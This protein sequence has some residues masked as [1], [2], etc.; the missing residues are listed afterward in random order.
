MGFLYYNI[1]KVSYQLKQLF[2]NLVLWLW[3]CIYVILLN[4]LLYVKIYDYVLERSE[5]STC[6]QLFCCSF[7]LHQCTWTMSESLWC[8]MFR[9]TNF[10]RIWI[11]RGMLWT[12][13]MNPFTIWTWAYN[14]KS[15][16]VVWTTQGLSC[17][18][19]KA[20]KWV[21]KD[22]N[23]SAYLRSIQGPRSLLWSWHP[24][25]ENVETCR[26]SSSCCKIWMSHSFCHEGDQI[27]A[28]LI[29]LATPK[30]S[31]VS[32]RRNEELRFCHLD[33]TESVSYCWFV[34]SR[35]RKILRRC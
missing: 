6:Q 35:Y 23:V 34:G 14:F 24:D 11:S 5:D 8:S 10:W 26:V 2:S 12:S 19:M 3:H 28:T 1:F 4:I 15:F 17:G 29:N 33:P 25:P 30:C 7:Y 13:M 9:S 18:D 32:Q 31:F 21:M 16:E 20:C 22:S 27:L